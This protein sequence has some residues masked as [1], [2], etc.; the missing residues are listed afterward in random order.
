MWMRCEQ[1]INRLSERCYRRSEWNNFNSR[2][3][4]CRRRGGKTNIRERKGRNNDYE[5]DEEVRR[6]RRT[7]YEYETPQKS[8]SGGNE[9]KRSRT[10]RSGISSGKVREIITAVMEHGKC[11][12]ADDDSVENEED[13]ISLN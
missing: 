11:E 6:D 10:R 9:G 1:L 13:F 7:D 2:R 3:T 8:A 5:Y 12:V 4:N